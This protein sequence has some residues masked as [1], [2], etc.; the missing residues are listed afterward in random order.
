MG[1]VLERSVRL[2]PLTAADDTFVARLSA[3]AFSAFDP[4]AGPH[5]LALTRREDVVTR[6]A[7]RDAR[8]LGFVSVEFSRGAAWIQAI[9]VSAHERGSGVGG[10][11]MA[12]AIRVARRA[13]TRRLHLTTAQANVEALELFLK[14]GFVIERRLPRFYTHGQDACVLGRAL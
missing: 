11:L 7:V 1:A 6:V 10:K 9:A 12:E 14:C 3:E 4:H 13:G 5:T 2:R 8:R